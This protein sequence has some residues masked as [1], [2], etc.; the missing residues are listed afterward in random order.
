MFAALAFLAML[1]VIGVLFFG[2]HVL[3]MILPAEHSWQRVLTDEAIEART[4][5][6]LKRWKAIAGFALVLYFVVVT[7]IY[8]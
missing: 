4:H 1:A 3:R 8:S 6:L 7:V 2:G 5:V